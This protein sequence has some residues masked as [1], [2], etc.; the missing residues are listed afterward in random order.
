MENSTLNNLEQFA[1]QMKENIGQAYTYHEFEA[2]NPDY[3]Q[4]CFNTQVTRDSIR[5]FVDGIGD[6]N[7]L[8]RDRI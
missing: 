4:E 5:H 3:R 6:I 7:P 1:T 2:A 8:F